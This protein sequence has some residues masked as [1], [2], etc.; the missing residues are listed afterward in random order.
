M[1]CFD[2][3]STRLHCNNIKYNFI[4]Y[5]NLN[6]KGKPQHWLQLQYKLLLFGYMG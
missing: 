1:I 5:Q 6:A 4:Q 3:V 2:Q